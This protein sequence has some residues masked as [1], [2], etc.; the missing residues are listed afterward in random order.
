MLVAN[1][2]NLLLNTLMICLNLLIRLMMSDLFMLA[3]VFTVFIFA[4]I[5]FFMLSLFYSCYIKNENK[6]LEL[7]EKECYN[8]DNEI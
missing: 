7:D 3:K 8:D 4:C 5:L 2:M 6:R 1:F